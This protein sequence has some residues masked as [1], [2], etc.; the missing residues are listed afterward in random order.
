ML[1]NRYE[2]R[3]GKGKK[4]REKVV[5]IRESLNRCGLFCG[6]GIEG[7]G[8]CGCVNK[9]RNGKKYEIEREREKSF[10]NNIFKGFSM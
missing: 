9:K 8:L 1:C 5:Y 10:Y 6:G 2:K 4:K 7:W 3:R